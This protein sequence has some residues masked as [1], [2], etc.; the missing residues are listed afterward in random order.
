MC[1]WFLLCLL[2]HSFFF[3]CTYES[4]C[5][6]PGVDVRVSWLPLQSCTTKTLSLSLSLH[7]SMSTRAN[8]STCNQCLITTST[9]VVLDNR[10]QEMDAD[11]QHVDAGPGVS[12]GDVD[13]ACMGAPLCNQS[14]FVH[15]RTLVSCGESPSE[16]TRHHKISR[17]W[18]FLRS[19]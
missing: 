10:A 19:L 8:P 12:C 5:L 17:I 6:D 9:Q 7:L 11:L 14:S 3:S 15:P 2:V 13:Q 4:A 1:I 16:H 18:H